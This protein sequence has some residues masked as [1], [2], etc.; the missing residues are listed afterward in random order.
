MDSEFSNL[1]FNNTDLVYLDSAATTLTPDR[2]LGVMSD[3][4][5]NGG[6]SPGRG[7]HS[8]SLRAS[9]EYSR[10]REV[11]KS[12][13]GVP[14]SGEMFFCHNVTDGINKVALGLTH[15]AHHGDVIAITEMEHN[16]N[17]LPWRRLAEQSGAHLEILPVNDNGDVD[18]SLLDELTTLRV[19][20]VAISMCSNINGARPKL[21][22]LSRFLDSPETFVVLDGAQ[23]GGHQPVNFEE[24]GADFAVV[25][26]HKMYGPKGIAGVLGKKTSLDLLDPVIVGGGTVLSSENEVNYL[27]VPERL[28][29]GTQDVAAAIGWAEA[30][31]WLEELGWSEIHQKEQALLEKLVS[32]LEGIDQVLI[33]DR[34]ET[35]NSSVISFALQ[36]H[37]SHD[38]NSY[39]VKRNICV[40]IGH[41]CSPLFLKALN[42]L[43][44][45]RISLGIHNTPDDIDRFLDALKS[46]LA[47]VET[48]N[49]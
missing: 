44:L 19:R 45:C 26:S 37:H 35:P 32:G 46:F 10:C 20:V 36:G 30:C 25:S 48:Q 11:I 47:Q 23:A 6:G 27:E 13:F 28:E 3:Y 16:S 5:H 1:A 38:L 42:V 39:L 24:T 29:A 31:Q 8:L 14:E 34:G 12:F 21:E 40:R 43:E 17:Y 18:F 7:A 9:K 15:L 22:Q 4:Y 41:M 33:V 2:V 49:G